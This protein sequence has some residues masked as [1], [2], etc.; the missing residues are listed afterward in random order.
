[1]KLPGLDGKTATFILSAARK[2]Q[3]HYSNPSST[4]VVPFSSYQI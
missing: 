3:P 2:T 4:E 1:M